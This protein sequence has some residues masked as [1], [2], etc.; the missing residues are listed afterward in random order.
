MRHVCWWTSSCGGVY[1][2]SAEGIRALYDACSELG[3]KLDLERGLV[4]AWG[5]LCGRL[6]Q[7]FVL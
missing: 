7:L 1:Y 4:R 3:M 5:V 2:D 6:C